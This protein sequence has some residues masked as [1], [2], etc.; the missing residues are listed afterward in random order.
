MA[1]KFNTNTNKSVT[2]SV[3]IPIYMYTY[4]TC[5]H[6]SQSNKTTQPRRVDHP[7]KII[8]NSNKNFEY[9]EGLAQKKIYLQIILKYLPRKIYFLYLMTPTTMYITDNSKYSENYK[10]NMQYSTKS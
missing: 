5:Q 9:D 4:I 6:T 10:L 2:D 8:I 3:S 7:L 1:M